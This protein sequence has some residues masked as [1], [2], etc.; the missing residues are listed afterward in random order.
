[1]KYM[2]R[3]IIYAILFSASLTSM[4]QYV[5]FVDTIFTKRLKSLNLQIELPYNDI[6]SSN[7]RTHTHKNANYTAKSIGAFFAERKYIDSVLKVAGLPKDLEYLP[8]AV[9][10]M[11]PYTQSRFHCAGVWQLPYFV[12]INYGLRVDNEI[13]ERYD[14][15]KSTPVAVAYLK[16]L[17]EKYIDW[18][19]VVIAYA[20]S[21]AALEA[22]KIRTNNNDDVWN[23]YYNG[24]LSN[25]SIIPDFITY[26][27]LVNFHQ[28]HRI[29]PIIPESGTEAFPAIPM[30]INMTV[31]Q[32][33]INTT[34]Q[35]KPTVTNSNVAKPKSDDKKKVIYTVKSGDTLTRISKL[36]KVSIESIQKWNGL[37]SDRIN[38]GQKLVIYH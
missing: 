17:S 8:L 33:P 4:G 30:E 3:I 20:N 24:N 1:M 16:K 38:I 21:S 25:R 34:A 10:R 18:W 35:T 5:D 15:R 29:Q 27:Y 14:I 36:Y 9:S 2:R 11:N 7:I 26:I 12:A 13:D 22:A 23:L 32:R 37:K 19:D 31:A 6:V 28:S